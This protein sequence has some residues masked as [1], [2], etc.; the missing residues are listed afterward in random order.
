[1]KILLDVKDN[2][3][4][5][6]MEFLKSISFIKTAKPYKKNEVTNASLLQSIEAYEKGTQKPTPLSLVK[7][8]K[9]LHA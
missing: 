6:A 1:M 4:E 9:M 8:K 2:K 3:A 5:F 7:L